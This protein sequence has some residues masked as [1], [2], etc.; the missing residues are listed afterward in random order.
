[1]RLTSARLAGE[2]FYR[3]EARPSRSPNYPL[4]FVRPLAG[5]TSSSFS[6]C[7]K[8]HNGSRSRLGSDPGQINWKCS[9]GGGLL[10]RVISPGCRSLARSL[11]FGLP[12]ESG[13]QSRPCH[14]IEFRTGR[15]M[16][17][18]ICSVEV[19]KWSR[20]SGC[21]WKLTQKSIAPKSHLWQDPFVVAGEQNRSAARRSNND[22]TLV[23]LFFLWFVF[24]KMPKM[25]LIDQNRELRTKIG[26]LS[27]VS[28]VTHRPPVAE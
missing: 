16:L 1:M 10:K 3:K 5:T 6:R 12:S 4:P 20:A 23:Y 21:H 11:S 7:L 14:L 25:C 19:S 9:G 17:I 15:E 22:A 8:V 28:D 24:A 27:K 2:N 26:V 18:L 13:G